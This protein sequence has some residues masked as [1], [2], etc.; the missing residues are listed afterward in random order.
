MLEPDIKIH[1]TVFMDIS[2][3]GADAAVKDDA[4]IVLRLKLLLIKW[5]KGHY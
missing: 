1:S 2:I 5:Y 3:D 4:A